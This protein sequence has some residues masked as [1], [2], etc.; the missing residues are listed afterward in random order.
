VSEAQDAI[1]ALTLAAGGSPE[2]AARQFFSQQGVQAGRSGRDSIGGLPAYTAFFEAATE[3][4]VL[5][6]EV[7]FLSYAGKLYRILGYTPAERFARYQDAFSATLHSFGRLTDARYL[8]VQPKRV[9]LVNPE[10]PMALPEFAQTYPSTVE[11]ETIGLINGI[12][13]S[14]TFPR[15][16]LA[17]RVVGGRLPN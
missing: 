5:R 13:Q 12:A 8:D 17:K 10:R 14:E 11:L 2:Q 7:T 9:A 15:G 4:G 6:G 3:Q 1:I 16:E